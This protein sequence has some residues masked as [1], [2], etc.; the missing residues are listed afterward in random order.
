MLVFDVQE[1]PWDAALLGIYKITVLC[2]SLTYKNSITV[3]LMFPA[4]E[5]ESFVG[6]ILQTK[7]NF[8]IYD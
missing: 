3:F 5:Q 8:K 1:K 6:Q 4:S 2:F 7:L